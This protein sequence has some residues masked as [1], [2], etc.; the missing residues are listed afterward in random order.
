MSKFFY[1][2]TPDVMGTH[3]TAGYK[4]NRDIKLGSA[5]KP[6]TLVVT[7][8]ERQ[9]EILVIVA[10]HN[11]IANIEINADEK[12]NIVELE[13]VLNTPK[14]QRFDKT[15][16]RNDPCSCGSTKKYKKCCG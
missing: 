9:E 1:R 8:K 15:P 13:A 10:A 4:P 3:G 11:F 5:A 16:S 7:S 14:T 6:L 12:E 2:G